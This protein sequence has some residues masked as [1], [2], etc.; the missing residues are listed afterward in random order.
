M[1]TV[2]SPCGRPVRRERRAVPTLSLPPPG[3]PPRHESILTCCKPHAP[4]QPHSVASLARL[5]G[6]ARLA[7]LRSERMPRR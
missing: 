2:H 5:A 3:A 4:A 7:H 1:I 6:L